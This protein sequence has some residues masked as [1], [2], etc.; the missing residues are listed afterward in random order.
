MARSTIHAMSRP[1]EWRVLMGYWWRWPRETFRHTYQKWW[2]ADWAPSTSSHIYD[3]G[4]PVGEK[5]RT[6]EPNAS[7]LIRSQLGNAFERLDSL[8]SPRYMIPGYPVP[9]FPECQSRWA[10]SSS[11]AESWSW[12]LFA[13]RFDYYGISKPFRARWCPTDGIRSPNNRGEHGGAISSRLWCSYQRSALAEWLGKFE[14]CAWAQS[15]KSPKV[16]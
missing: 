12:R 7:A 16:G 4:S 11:L 9:L 8:S 10:G 2:L 1:R 14:N 6:L 5:S 15:Y 13:F 3:W